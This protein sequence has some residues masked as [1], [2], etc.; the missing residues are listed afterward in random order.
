MQDLSN[1]SAGIQ[2]LRYLDGEKHLAFVTPRGLSLPRA[3]DDKG[4]AA[5]ASDARVAMHVVFT[6]GVVGAPP[7]RVVQ[8]PEGTRI[9]MSSVPS[10]S[11]VFSQT[12]NVQSLRRVAERTGG[13]LT[14][15]RKADEGFARLDQ[16]T[17]FQYLLGYYP[18][19]ANWNGAFRRIDVKVN[20]PGVTV[21]FRRGYFASQQLV[22]LDRR[23]FMTHT[24]MSAAGRYDGELQDIRVTLRMPPVTGEQGARQLAIEGSIDLSRVSFTQVDGRHTAA[25]DIAIY[26]GDSREQVIG[27]TL[28]RVDLK[29]SDES[30]ET[31]RRSGVPFSAVLRVAESPVYVK[32][33]VFDYA[34]DLL[35]SAVV[36]M[37]K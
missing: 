27:E 4:L 11:A 24:R 3:E 2:Y 13:Q 32:V 18:L 28:K 15:F 35:G 1:L 8:G 25:L 6:G 16:S 22:P 31:A 29:L 5:V 19:D 20:R 21:L 10:A 12:F 9:V 14:A 36:R 30:Y 7:P 33:I 37:R 26:A 23:E 17:R 34:S